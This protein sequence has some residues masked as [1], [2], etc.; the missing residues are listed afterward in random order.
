MKQRRGGVRAD[1]E[2]ADIADRLVHLLG[3]LAELIV[4]RYERRQL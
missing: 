3:Q 4:L 2:I 1:Q